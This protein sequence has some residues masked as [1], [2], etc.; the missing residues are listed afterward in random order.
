[1]RAAREAAREASA[2]VA[3]SVAAAAAE[4]ASENTVSSGAAK[5]EGS[6]GR[7]GTGDGSGRE[8]RKRKRDPTTSS[9]GMRSEGGVGHLKKEDAGSGVGTGDAGS[10]DELRV[11]ARGGEA[12]SSNHRGVTD[13]VDLR[14]VDL[15]EEKA[16]ALDAQVTFSKLSDTPFAP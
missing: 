1:M 11:G 5:S 6:K 2:A 4:A 10:D 15:S 13:D 3:A 9:S 7:S 14:F 12:T 8:E 16:A